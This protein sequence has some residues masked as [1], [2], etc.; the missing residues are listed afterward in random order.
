M[1]INF[2]TSAPYTIGVEEEFQL[3]D[4]ASFALVPAMV[5]CSLPATPRGSPQAP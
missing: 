1:E 4:P 3:V 5:L 2:G